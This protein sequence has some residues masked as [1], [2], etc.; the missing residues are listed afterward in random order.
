[1]SSFE[2]PASRNLGFFADVQIAADS[3]GNVYVP[4]VSENEVLEYSSS[5]TLLK[6]FTGSGAGA[7]K[8]P[9][10]VAIDSSGDLWVADSGNNRIVELDSGG[11]PV[12]VNGKP[13]EIKSEG[14]WSVA[15]DGH[16]D[17]FALVAN[18][19]DSCGARTRPACISSSIARKAGRSPTWGLALSVNL[20]AKSNATTAGLAVNR[21]ERACVRERWPANH[22]NVW[23][24]GP[25]TAPLVEKEL[26]AEV[27]TS[28]VKLGAL[29]NP[30]GIATSYRFEYGPTSAYGSSTPFPEGASVKEWNRTR[31]GRPRAA[32]RPGPPTTIVSWQATNWERPTAPTRPSPR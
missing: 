9:T 12:E 31:C 28:E 7:L 14:V 32:S 4:V 11:A 26:T 29:V 5:G 19:A 8:E 21:G 22:W 24:F 13:V 3:A 2:V 25:P 1:M 23:V 10:G 27:G 18:G 6:T 30:G 17:V 16:G 15:L 20:A